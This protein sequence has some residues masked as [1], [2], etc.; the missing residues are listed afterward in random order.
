MTTLRVCVVGDSITNGTGDAAFL[1][2]PGR[3]AAGERARGHDL[4]LYNLGVRADTSA[5]ILARWRSECRA[6]LPPELPCALLFMFGVND[7]AEESDRGL[8]VPL[9]Q[10]LANARAIIAEAKAW[11]PTLWLGPPPVDEAQMPFDSPSGVRRD[12]R[13]SRVLATSDAY[14]ALATE[15]EVPFLDLFRP[16]AGDPRWQHA[17]EAGDGVH[18][19]GAGYAVIAEHVGRWAAWRAWMAD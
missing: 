18:P 17:L 14:A 12:M 6:R 13:N 10:S 9:E 1:G 5:L 8:R 19:L 15:L 4:T 3:L 7:T 16:L 11:L 2:W